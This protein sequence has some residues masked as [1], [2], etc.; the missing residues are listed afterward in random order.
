M[1]RS[2]PLSTGALLLLPALVAAPANAD[3]NASGSSDLAAGC[4]A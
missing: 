2:D 1:T 4:R 3:V